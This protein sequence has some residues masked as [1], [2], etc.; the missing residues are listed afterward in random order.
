M[1]SLH[2]LHKVRLLCFCFAVQH[3]SLSLLSCLP[4]CLTGPEERYSS[5]AGT[6]ILVRLVPT[7]ATDV[8]V[9]TKSEI[10]MRNYTEIPPTAAAAAAASLVNRSNTGVC[11]VAAKQERAVP[12]VAKRFDWSLSS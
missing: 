12:S 10:Y 2:S 3:T 11:T 4:A 1:Q 5:I 9:D 8:T 7:K 6:S